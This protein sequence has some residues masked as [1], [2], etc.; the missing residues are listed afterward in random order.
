VNA[1]RTA[2]ESVDAYIAGFPDDVQAVLEQI[3]ATI[4]D[5]APGAV[6]TISYQIPTFM[7]DGH[8]LVYF[9]GFKK[10]VSVYPAPVENPEFREAMAIYGSGR[11]TAKFRLDR[12]IPFDLITRIVEFRIADHRARAAAKRKKKA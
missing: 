4:R 9:A 2:P 11:G 3:R 5:A 12:P 8:P 7:L 10:H 1:E 6:E